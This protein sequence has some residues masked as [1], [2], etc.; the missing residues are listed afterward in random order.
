MSSW[1]TFPTLQ[2][3]QR[4]S[5]QYNC[6]NKTKTSKN[7][8]LTGVKNLIALS[9]VLHVEQYVR[10]T[11]CCLMYVLEKTVWIY[12]IE[13]LLSFIELKP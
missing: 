9:K 2:K 8:F 12:K 3:A 6:S 13:T 5:V 10:Q 7:Y 11:M 4:D 1:S